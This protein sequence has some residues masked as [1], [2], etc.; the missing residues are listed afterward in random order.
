MFEVKPIFYIFDYNNIKLYLIF[1]FKKGK[2]LDLG[3][4]FFNYF[5]N[6]RNRFRGNS[7]GDSGSD[8]EMDT[9]QK[10]DIIDIETVKPP[11]IEG[12]FWGIFL[13]MENNYSVIN[14][15]IPIYNYT[16]S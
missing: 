3:F 12:V 10:G 8:G 16:Y 5:S 1:S 7:T 15:M 4:R 2:D 11:E 14:T 6:I 9:T 13:V